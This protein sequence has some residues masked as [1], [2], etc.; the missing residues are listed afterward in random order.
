M[1]SLNKLYKNRKV[2]LTIHCKYKYFDSTVQ[3][4]EDR[5]QKF[6][7]AVCRLPSTFS[8]TSALISLLFGSASFR[9]DH[10]KKEVRGGQYEDKDVIRKKNLPTV[11]ANSFDHNRARRHKVSNML[12]VNFMFGLLKSNP[13]RLESISCNRNELK[14]CINTRLITKMSN[15]TW[16]HADN[17]GYHADP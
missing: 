13:W 17:S 10:A 5:R 6:M 1:L 12:T 3:R 2:S 11:F 9:E 16:Q 7:F 14:Q 15:S 8:L 4:A